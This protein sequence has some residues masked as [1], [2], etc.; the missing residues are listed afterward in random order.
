MCDKYDK[1]ITL[2]HEF[3]KVNKEKNVLNFSGELFYND[4]RCGTLYGELKKT[5]SAK[6]EPE[7]RIRTFYFDLCNGEIM[8]QGLNNYDLSGDVDTVTI[9]TGGTKE[10]EGI[11]GKIV[12]NRKSESAGV[13]EHILY[14]NW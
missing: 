11:S 10:Y 3:S 12:T 1:V 8:S 7:K 9:I 13:C 6:G 14:I 5:V 4:K 2:K